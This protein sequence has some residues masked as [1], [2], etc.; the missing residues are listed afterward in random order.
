MILTPADSYIVL[1]ASLPLVIA[2]DNLGGY[3]NSICLGTYSSV[4]SI[5]WC[6]SDA[7][8]A[9]VYNSPDSN[10]AD[11]T[12]SASADGGHTNFFGATGGNIVGAGMIGTVGGGFGNLLIASN[13]PVGVPEPGT[14]TLLVAALLGL[15]GAAYLRRRRAM[16]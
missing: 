5:T 3:P 7:Y 1:Y 10:L 16:A 6:Y 14:L 9:L 12:Y 11:C 13:G 4:S 2:P 15:A 8:P